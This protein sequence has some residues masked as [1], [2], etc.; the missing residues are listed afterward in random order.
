MAITGPRRVATLLAAALVVAVAVSAGQAARGALKVSANDETV[1][2][3]GSPDAGYVAYR[4]NVFGCGSSVNSITYTSAY[5]D[6]PG[7]IIG[8]ACRFISSLPVGWVESNIRTDSADCNPSNPGTEQ[9][10][11]STY[12]KSFYGIPIINRGGIGLANCSFCYTIHPGSIVSIYGGDLACSTG[13]TP[14]G[15]IIVQFGAS[16]WSLPQFG[17]SVFYQSPTQI[18]VTLPTTLPHNSTVFVTI[19]NC[20]GYQS[21]SYGLAI[22]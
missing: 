18:N 11:A 13:S 7:T 9:N 8:T 15:S 5:V 14:T 22:T 10:N 4:V 19:R 21:A 12:T 6:A 20:N 17:D 1:C 3:P 2:A 16:I